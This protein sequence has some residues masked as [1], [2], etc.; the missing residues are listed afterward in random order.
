MKTIKNLFAFMCLNV[1]AWLQGAGMCVRFC[2]K[3]GNASC[4]QRFGVRHCD[5]CGYHQVDK[6]Q[7]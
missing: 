5:A 2:P 4:L 7:I 1:W 6:F 3:C